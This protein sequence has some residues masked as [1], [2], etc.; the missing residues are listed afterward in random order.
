MRVSA[1]AAT[2]TPHRP[3]RRTGPRTITERTG[4]VPG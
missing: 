1:Y 3:L 2:G 4:A